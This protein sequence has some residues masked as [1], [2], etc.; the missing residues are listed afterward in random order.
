[1]RDI[2]FESRGGECGTV[3][4]RIS[5]GARREVCTNPANGF[6]AL[7]ASFGVTKAGVEDSGSF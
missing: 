4:Y 5:G 1:M 6:Q 2:I 7:R 3:C